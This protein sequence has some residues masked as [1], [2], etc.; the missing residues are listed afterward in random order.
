MCLVTLTDG[1]R[2][3]LQKRFIDVVTYCNEIP[4]YIN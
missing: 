1:G 4:G 2:G 3:T